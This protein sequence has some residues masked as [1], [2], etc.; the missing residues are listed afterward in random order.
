IR[1][2]EKV[3]SRLG[4]GQQYLITFASP[5]VAFLLVLVYYWQPSDAE[6]KLMASYFLAAGSVY[7]LVFMT[8]GFLAIQGRAR[9]MIPSVVRMPSLYPS[10]GVLLLLFLLA[11]L[12]ATPM[13]AGSDYVS[14]FVIRTTT[15][16]YVLFAVAFLFG[17]RTVSRLLKSPTVRT[18][19]KKRLRETQQSRWR[20]AAYFVISLFVMS[21][22]LYNGVLL[23][24]IWS[25]HA[26]IQETNLVLGITVPYILVYLFTGVA[27][28]SARK[29]AYETLSEEYQSLLDEHDGGRLTSGE[30]MERLDGLLSIQDSLDTMRGRMFIIDDLLDRDE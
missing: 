18:E 11:A 16:V 30:V 6:Q 8:L 12:F 22:W 15:L 29:S 19:F 2:N 28:L 17:G 23:I 3:A 9:L 13:V 24:D 26:R 4:R 25:R 1:K 20:F 10:L 21:L 5:F 14:F 7:M 27:F